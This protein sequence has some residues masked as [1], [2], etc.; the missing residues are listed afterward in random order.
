MRGAVAYL[1]WLQAAKFVLPPATSLQQCILLSLSHWA[2]GKL[3]AVN[4]AVFLSAAKTL[5]TID[6]DSIER[7]LMSLIFFM[8]T[9]QRLKMSHTPF[10]EQFKT[11]ASP[12]LKAHLVID[13]EKQKIFV[14]LAVLR[15]AIDRAKLPIPDY[16][17]AIR[18]FAST[19]STTGF[20]AG[21]DGFVINQPYWDAEATRWRKLR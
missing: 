12:N 16:D 4:K 8:A 20:E 18:A 17:A 9:A 15:N 6:S 13:D 21:A 3:D 10:Y 14:N 5:R 11:G 1:G 7:R 2:L 19:V